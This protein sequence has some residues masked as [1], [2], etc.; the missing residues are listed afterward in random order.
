MVEASADS[1]EQLRSL[2]NEE[3]VGVRKI[4]NVIILVGL[5]FNYRAVDFQ[6]I[7]RRANGAD[8]DASGNFEVLGVQVG[9]LFGKL[10][11]TSADIQFFN[12]VDRFGFFFSRSLWRCFFRGCCRSGY[13]F[14]LGGLTGKPRLKNKSG[15]EQNNDYNC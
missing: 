10:A 14:R 9:E 13:G 7:G 8:A 3:S 15:N 2:R 4:V 12:F 11:H 1:V 6:N 5:N